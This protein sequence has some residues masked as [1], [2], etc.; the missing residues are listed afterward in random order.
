MKKAPLFLAL[1]LMFFFVNLNFVQAHIEYSDAL[2]VDSNLAG[3]SPRVACNPDNPDEC[4]I[5]YYVSGSG[6]FF[7]YTYNG[8]DS[9]GSAIGLPVTVNYATS[10]IDSLAVNYAL[11]Y[12][13]YYYDGKFWIAFDSGTGNSY[14][15]TWANGYLFPVS[16]WSKSS[17]ISLLEIQEVNGEPLVFAMEISGSY[18]NKVFPKW[19]Y[20]VNGTIESTLPEIVTSFPTYDYIDARGFV[21]RY[22]ATTRYNITVSVHD[23]LGAWTNGTIASMGSFTEQN[24]GIW[25]WD[26]TRLVYRTNESIKYVLTSDLS[27]F[28]LSNTYYTFN[29]SIQESINYT[30]YDDVGGKATYGFKRYSN[31]TNNYG[32]FAAQMPLRRLQIQYM[33]AINLDDLSYENVNVTAILEC[34]EYDLTYTEAGSEFIDFYTPCENNTLTLIAS[35]NYYPHISS[36]NVIL[37]E[38]CERT[39][40]PI[41]KQ[42]RKPYTLTVRVADALTGE[43]VD[44][45]TVNIDGIINT[46]DSN[47]EA[48]IGNFFPVTNSDFDISPIGSC[49]YDVLFDGEPKPVSVIVTKAGYD[50]FTSTEYFASSP[51]GDPYSDFERDYSIK[52]SP[53]STRLNVKAFTQDGVKIETDAADVNVYGA[54][55]TYLSEGG[56][57]YEQSYSTKLPSLFVLVDNRSSYQVNVTLEYCGSYYQ[58]NVTIVGGAYQDAIFDLNEKSNS[59]C[60]QTTEDCPSSFCEGR[61]WKKLDGC[62]SI[63]QYTSIDCGSSDLCDDKRGCFDYKGTQ[64]CET[65]EDCLQ[66]SQCISSYKSRTGLCGS[67][68]L[69]IFKD[70]LCDSCNETTGLC[71]ESE[72]CIELGK[73]RHRFFI[74][75]TT[76]PFIEGEYITYSVDYYCGLDNR[77]ERT[78][79]KGTSVPKSTDLVGITTMPD[80]WAYTTNSTHYIFSDISVYCDNLCNVTY[81]YCEYGCNEETGYCYESP[82][83]PEGQISIYTKMFA[84]WW[85]LFFPTSAS[86]TLAYIFIALILSGVLTYY[87]GKNGSG[88]NGI[89]FVSS[90]IAISLAG[91]V[92]GT[93]PF[94]VGVLYAVLAGFLIMKMWR[95]A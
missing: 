10:H 26:G 66:Y 54:N 11:P 70:V 74:R 29:S 93:I 20:L 68:N 27:S 12:D 43:R 21:A 72:L 6:L 18:A 57:Y 58:Q 48:L 37:N 1:T 79:I 19:Y 94:F 31:Q 3:D 14:V 52:L 30:S 80:A 47:G 4:V 46:T 38:T 51:L 69:C 82:S 9:V 71:V 75:A 88:N 28:G 41:D 87:I 40:V 60:C 32:I 35:G 16:V 73:L 61:Y 5:L 42:Y 62:S 49:Q 89:V 81:E 76:Q 77:G 64:S 13:V 44:G 17:L 36:F 8:F 22:N 86:Q 85:Y 59:I 50:T 7:R 95:G 90:T 45:V 92:I 25:Y 78:C 84:D 63:C 56:T 15:Y 65:D 33:S 34:N 23:N 39:I 2:L 53:P 24:D 55:K 83:S 67:D 91:V